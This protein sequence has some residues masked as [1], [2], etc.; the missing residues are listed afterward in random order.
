[1]PVQSRWKVD[2]PDAHLATLL[3][4]SPAYRLSQQDKCFIDATRP[5]S[6][7]FTKHEFRLWSQ[8]FA[9]GLR[10]SGIQNGD[11][12]LFFSGNNIFFPVVYMG[13]IMAG[14]IFTSAN[15]SYVARELAFQLEDS[16]ATYLICHEDFLDTGNVGAAMAGLGSKRRFIFNDKLLKDSTAGMGVEQAR[17]LWRYWGD[18]VA[19]EEEGRKFH[20]DDLS[21]PEL[22]SRTLAINYSSGT[23]GVPKGVEVS[24]KNIIANILQYNYLFYLY[25][26]HKERLARARWLCTLPMYHAMAQNMYV[27]IALMRQIPVYIMERFNL[28][29]FLENIQRYKITDLSLVPPIVVMMAKSP[30]TKQYDLSSIENILCGAAPLGKEVAQEAEGLWLD[31]R[32]NIKQGWGMTE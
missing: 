5:E 1:M 25:P 26:N 13:I 21:T 4:Q 17:P 8:R 30:M 29:K 23:T 12:V 3:F 6:H 7:H 20:W 18:L 24:H 11:R 22:S 16:R 27:G 19:S 31:G 15:P 32:V 10:A 2:I 28:A 14:A 9:A